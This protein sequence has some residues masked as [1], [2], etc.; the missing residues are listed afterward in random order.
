MK[1]HIDLVKAGSV[2]ARG[3]TL[4][5]LLVGVAIGLIGVVVMFQVL[6]VGES[7]KRSTSAGSDSQVAGTVAMFGLERDIRPAG[8][9]FARG[10]DGGPV[11]SFGCTVSV[12]GPAATLPD[13]VLL[14]PVRIVN[15]AGGAPDQ[16]VVFYGNSSLYVSTQK[17]KASTTASKTVDGSYGGF[18]VGDVVVAG[19]SDST[20]GCEMLEVSSTATLGVLDHAGLRFNSAPTQIVPTSGFLY[21]LGPLPQR[22]IWSISN[23]KLVRTD[24][25]Y[26]ATPVEVADNIIDLQA[27]Y[28]VDG[29][30]GGNATDGKLEDGNWT[31]TTPANWGRL[32][33]I[34]V[35][36]LSRSQQ[37][38][39]TEVT[40]N[41][42][43]WS[44]GTFVMSDIAGATGDAANWKRYR[45]HVY[46]KVIPLRNLVWGGDF[47]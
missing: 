19:G 9:G 15:G 35:A 7:L 45:Y 42:P 10:T 32:L 17:Y 8:L 11:P 39:K 24:S 37:F 28:G 38:E 1:A 21:N 40:P 31:N 34:R 4:V 27:Q 41:A 3:F 47:N 33:A 22:N 23:G 18:K 26:S 2:H 5:E 6:S 36:L 14:E 29:F 30:G 43:T 20:V 16:I 13:P 12:K 25:L 44:G 46:E